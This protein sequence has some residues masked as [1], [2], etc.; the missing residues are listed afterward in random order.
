M[1]RRTVTHIGV[2]DGEATIEQWTWS[3]IVDTDPMEYRWAAFPD[4]YWDGKPDE[5]EEL[6]DLDGLQGKLDELIR[7]F[8]ETASRSAPGDG[9]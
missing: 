1:S 2:Y 3:L 6:A 4:G 9:A 5:I 8:V 7:R